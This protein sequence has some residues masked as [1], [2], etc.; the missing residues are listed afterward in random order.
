MKFKSV[1]T[2]LSSPMA[3]VDKGILEENGIVAVVDNENAIG[4]D[5]LLQAAF[6]HIQLSVPDQDWE[7]AKEILDDRNQAPMLEKV[8][9][10][11][12]PKCGSDNIS[13]YGPYMWTILVP[14]LFPLLFVQRTACHSCGYKWKRQ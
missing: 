12:C 13:D 2:Y 6:G 11:A 14:I 8:D 7:A 4:A 5:G 10:Y 9:A 3:H 1:K